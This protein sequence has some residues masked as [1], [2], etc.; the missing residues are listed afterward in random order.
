M[1]ATLNGNELVLNGEINEN[2][3]FEGT[4]PNNLPNPCILNLSG[5]QKIN[6]TG[7]KFWIGYWEKQVAS[8]LKLQFKD[9]ST[10]I[11][12]QFNMVKSFLCGGDIISFAAPFICNGCNS[13]W[14]PIFEVKDVKDGS[15]PKIKC[16]KCGS[17]ENE[18]DEIEEEY[19]AFLTR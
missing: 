16:P 3:N 5:I 17:D 18:I 19:L 1:Q 2:T 9:A 8:G 14:S 7:V 11:V 4:I 12:E 15:F 10:A 6:S 13:E